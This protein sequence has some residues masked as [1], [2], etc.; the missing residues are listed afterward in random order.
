MCT[1]KMVKRAQTVVNGQTVEVGRE[2]HMQLSALVLSVSHDTVQS[3]ESSYLFQ[4]NIANCHGAMVPLV[5][6]AV[7]M[8]NR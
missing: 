6:V 4:I 7:A 8:R 2:V 5:A 1:S 3:I